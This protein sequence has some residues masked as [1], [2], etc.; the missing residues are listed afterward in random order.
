MLISII[1]PVYNTEKFL[2]RCIDSI[3]AQSYTDFE[4]LLID[5]GSKDSSGTICDEYAEK[6]SRVRVFHKENGG[7]SSAR[8]VGL[9][10]AKGEWVTFCDS[11]DYVASCWLQNYHLMENSDKS[12][13]CQ[14]LTR[15]QQGKNGINDLKIVGFNR[16]A[17]NGDVRQVVAMLFDMGMLGWIYIKAFRLKRIKEKG[18]TFDVRQRYRED[19]KFFLEYLLPSDKLILY[20]KADYFYMLAETNKYDDWKCTVDFSRFIYDN[21]KRLGF[22]SGSPIRSY[23]ANEY[24]DTLL[25]TIQTEKNKDYFIEELLDLIRNEFRYLQMFPLTKYMLRN[26]VTGI[27]SKIILKLHLLFKNRL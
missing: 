15:F 26:E 17:Y 6:D 1:V 7:V 11:D 18:I 3:L 23:F 24:K 8:N 13:I 5:D 9:D 14:G 21:I 10:N 2:H 27:F 25:N 4:L 22:E 12:V 16:G 19:E 20:D